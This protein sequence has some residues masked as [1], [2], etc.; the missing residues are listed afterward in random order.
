MLF[1]G[2]VRE[3]ITLL[4]PQASEEEIKQAVTVSCAEFVYDLENGL[5]FVLSEDGGGI[6]EGQAQRLAVARAL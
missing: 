6:S 4:R 3:N 2:T 1:S 5:D